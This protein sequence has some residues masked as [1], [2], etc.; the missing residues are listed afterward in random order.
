MHGGNRA[1]HDRARR[2]G[3][4]E[5]PGRLAGN[6]TEQQGERVDR[7]LREER[8][9]K[10]SEREGEDGATPTDL[11]T[12]YRDVEPSRAEAIVEAPKEYVVSNCVLLTSD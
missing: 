2:D 4:D 3:D 11:L 1:E 6:L 12:E 8:G 7:V 5:V 9:G 10:A